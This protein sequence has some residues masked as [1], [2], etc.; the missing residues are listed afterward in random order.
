[1]FGAELKSFS[2]IFHEMERENA[3]DEQNGPFLFISKLDKPFSSGI[4]F[5][6]AGFGSGGTLLGKAS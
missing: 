4:M 3:W 5:L 6:R 2:I 1:M